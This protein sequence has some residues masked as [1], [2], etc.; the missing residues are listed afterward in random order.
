MKLTSHHHLVP[1]SRMEL[2]LQFPTRLHGVVLNFIKHRDKLIL[3]YKIFFKGLIYQMISI[4]TVANI[5][6]EIRTQ[7]SPVYET[8]L[9]TATPVCAYSFTFKSYRI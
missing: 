1:S 5:L 8:V 2:Y 9:T 4:S 3:H 7:R 6:S